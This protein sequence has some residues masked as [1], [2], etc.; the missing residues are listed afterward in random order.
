MHIH[1]MENE[2]RKQIRTSLQQYILAWHKIPKNIDVEHIAIKRI[3]YVMNWGLKTA[4]E[5]G[6]IIEFESHKELLGASELGLST[7]EFKRA[8]NEQNENGLLFGKD[9]VTNQLWYEY[10]VIYGELDD[11]FD[12]VEDYELGGKYA[13]NEYKSFTTKYD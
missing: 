4:P 12:D 7:E 2:L 11:T 13:G 1:K 5:V 9:V 6:Y 10:P 8:I 3:R